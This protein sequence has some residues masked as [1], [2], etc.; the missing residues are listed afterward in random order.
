MKQNNIPNFIT[1]AE[2]SYNK[3]SK[4]WKTFIDSLKGIKS[5]SDRYE[6]P[7]PILAVLNT[8]F[9]DY[10]NTQD[11]YQNT[12]LRLQ[13]QAETSASKLGF[14]TY[15]HIPEIQTAIKNSIINHSDDFSVAP[16]EG[17]PSAI[18]NK[19]YGTKLANTIIKHYSKHI[20]ELSN[21]SPN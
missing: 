14:I 12:V 21:A 15:N 17:H 2:R 19:I 16:Y 8:G 5:I 10:N 11:W 3:N 7:P 1:V 6:L 9:M 20:L 13:D 4:N 18:M